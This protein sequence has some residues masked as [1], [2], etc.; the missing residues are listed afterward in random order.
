MT[1]PTRLPVLVLLALAAWAGPACTDLGPVEPKRV[2]TSNVTDWRDEVIYQLMVDRFANG[3]INNDYRVE[4]GH[5]GRY[6]GGD[7]QGVI[8]KLDYLEEL[9]VTALWI[10]P[11]VR[12]VEE[13]AGFASYHGYWTQDFLSVNPHFGDLA[14][15]RRLVDAAHARGMKVILDI[16]TNHVGQLFYYDVN[17][18]GQPDENVYGGG[19]DAP[20]GGTHSPV[21]HLTEYDPEYDPRGIQSYTSLGEGGPAPVRWIYLPE[22]NR[23][24]PLPAQ[25]QN[26]DWYHKRGRVTTWD[27]MEQTVYGDFPGGLKD[28]ATERDDVTDALIEVFKYWITAADFDGFRIDTLKHVEHAFWQ[29]FCPAMRRHALD[30]GKDKFFMFGEAFDGRDDLIGSFTFDGEVDSAFY[31]SQKFQVYDG[32]FKYGGA[33]RAIED[34]W[35]ARQTNYA[36]QPHENGIGV[37]PQQ[38]LVNFM[39][40]HDVP[41]FLWPGQTVAALHSALF[42]LLTQDGIPCIY[43]GTE[44]QFAGG[45]DPTNREP[46]W[47]SGYDTRNPT[48]QHLRALIDLRKQYAPLRRGDLVVRWST[49]HVADEQDAGIFAFERTYDGE[50]VLVVVNSRDAAAET[51]TSTLGG[52]DM[53]TSFAP[54]TVLVDKFTDDPNDRITVDAEGRVRIAVPARGGKVLVVE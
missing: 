54:G 39:D 7:Y 2:L 38:V 51:S 24:P 32:V 16:V 36:D 25:F 34:L 10:S 6:Q 37:P 40:N 3:D 43:Y 27:S 53:L 18:N 9:G 30:H 13:D 29:R 50:T 35:T 44:Q 22:L 26:L 19:D 21:W 5:L 31:F 17:G 41:R 20:T 1:K 28:L 49:D 33:T 23:V 8:D 12:N 45:N 11:V 14:A 4:P 47:W 52:S 46:L 15:L 42:L 48:F